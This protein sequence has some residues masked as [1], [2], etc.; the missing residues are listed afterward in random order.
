MIL[1]Q[2]MKFGPP[3]PAFTPH[4]GEVLVPLAPKNLRSKSPWYAD[5]F[6]A[7]KGTSQFDPRFG[8]V[9]V[10]VAL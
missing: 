3:P 7:K 2:K 9:L 10:P 6:A 5:H 8:K 4:C 1:Q